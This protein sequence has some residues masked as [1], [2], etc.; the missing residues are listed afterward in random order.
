MEMRHPPKAEH[1]EAPL[2]H[3]VLL[4]ALAA[5]RAAGIAAKTGQG[6]GAAAIEE[7]PI[8]EILL[9]GPDWRQALTAQRGSFNR[10]EAERRP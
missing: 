6:A 1:E 8:T 4:A 2:D 7:E 3:A 5:A 9:A 10:D